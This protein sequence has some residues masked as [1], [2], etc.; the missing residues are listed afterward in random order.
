LLDAAG[1]DHETS[2][3][4]W[5]KKPF[6]SAHLVGLIL[7]NDEDCVALLEGCGVH[8]AELRAAEAVKVG[9]V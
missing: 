5:T 7:D 2:V 4:L 9:E 6:N 8:T 3:Q 1:A